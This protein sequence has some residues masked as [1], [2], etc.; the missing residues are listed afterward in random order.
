MRMKTDEAKKWLRA[1][2]SVR[3]LTRY[4]HE[5]DRVTFTYVPQLAGCDVCLAG[6]A[7]EYPTEAAAILAA[8]R[9]QD[10]IR[11][12]HPAAE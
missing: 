2:P 8:S 4:D 10:A 6:E 9:F 12:N 7:D 3:P 5:R 11:A 1:T